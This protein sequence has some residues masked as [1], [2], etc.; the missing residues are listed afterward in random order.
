MA[1]KTIGVLGGMGLKATLHFF[2][3]LLDLTPASKD[4]D[5]L[6]VV[7]DSNPKIPDRTAAILGTGASPVPALVQ[8]A[9]ALEAAGADLIAIPCVTA[10]H[11]LD[12]LRPQTDLPILSILEI[13]V[14]TIDQEHPD[15]KTVGLLATSG[16]LKSGLFQKRLKASQ[17]ETLTPDQDGQAKVMA[18]IS[19]IKNVRP[20][21]DRAQISADLAAAAQGLINRGAQGIIAGCTEIPLGL[22]QNQLAVPYFDSLF[23]LARE[24]IRAAG[25]E[26]LERP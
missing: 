1:D 13:V 26:P 12:E 20:S 6:R 5:H 22:R 19:D 14:Q 16:T 3:L 17:I 18:A 24:A 2:K 10:H 4:Q 8:T 25:R 7:I 21:R 11:F 23:L 9:Q 15:I